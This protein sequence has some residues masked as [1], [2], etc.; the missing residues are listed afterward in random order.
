MRNALA[1]AATVVLAWAVGCN[2]WKAP[3]ATKKS[4]TSTAPA[5]Q[6]TTMAAGEFQGHSLAVYLDGKQTRIGK[7]VGSEQRWEAD[8]CPGN[9]A[10]KFQAD[11]ARLGRFESADLTIYPMK[12]NSL[13]DSVMYVNDKTRTMAPGKALTLDEF[14]RI[15]DRKLQKLARLP[16]G[17]YMFVLEV[18]GAKT[19]DWQKI[20]VQVK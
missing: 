19:W 1:F 7:K 4:T 11:S 3:W 14:E 5:T 16:A 17:T 8:R 2:D 18:K 10:I 6:P 12:G 15:S 20:V 13:D 9:P